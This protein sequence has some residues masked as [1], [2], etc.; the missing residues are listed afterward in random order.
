VGSDE[1]RDPIW[2]EW[3][4]VYHRDLPADA[5]ITWAKVVRKQHECHGRWS[6]HLSVRVPDT[7]QVERPN[8]SGAVAI[9]L[10]WR[11]LSDGLRVAYLRSTDG[12]DEHVLV[13]P[14]VV[15]SLRKADDIQGIRASRMNDIQQQLCVYRRGLKE[16]GNPKA[17][18]WIEA[19]QH[20]HAWKSAGRFA[21]L[22]RLWRAA[23]FE[24]D[25]LMYEAAE[26]W[27]IHDKHLWL[28]EANIRDQG[29]ARRLDQYRVLGARLSRRYQTL[30]LEDFDLRTFAVKKDK[31]EED[32]AS[33][34]QRYW[35][36]T[37]APHILRDVIKNA[38]TQRGGSLVE[39]P[40]QCTTVTCSVCGQ[41][42]KWDP[43]K[44]LY[45]TCSACGARWDQD[46]NAGDNLLDRWRRW[47]ADRERRGD[48]GEVPTKRQAKW[49]RL[50]Q[51]GSGARKQQDNSPTAQ[52][53]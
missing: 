6:L 29:I 50:G 53:E 47:E 3:P 7:W 52:G 13:D 44:E 20:M 12:L 40:A 9:D 16:D 5:E 27:R 26:T 23:R 32:P 46:A 18:W 14:A 37:A 33:T 38:F 35:Q 45:H 41:T 31:K 22:L 28:Y 17:A 4:V 24:G 49:A 51:H 36:K 48:T 43:G 11:T 1:H 25:E 15:G 21:S 34:A 30:V 2:A 8:T 19:T 10:G 39:V 42:D